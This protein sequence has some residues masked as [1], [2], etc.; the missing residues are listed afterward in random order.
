[1]HFNYM[2]SQQVGAERLLFVHV[3]FV[4]AVIWLRQ[5]SGPG[6]NVAVRNGAG[7]ARNRG[8]DATLQSKT[9]DASPVVAGN[10]GNV[11]LRKVQRPDI[12]SLRSSQV[13]AIHPIYLHS[14]MSDVSLPTPH[15]K[16]ARPTAMEARRK[17]Q[18][19][20]FEHTT[21]PDT[22]PCTNMYP[23]CLSSV[24]ACVCYTYT[25]T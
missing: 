8:P 22:A 24:P 16:K 15:L 20:G 17:E 25:S 21:G 23:A 2:P 18:L 10:C 1:V 14:A 5:E 9:G 19:Y 13:G 7:F 6:R 4:N 11:A 3:H 12:H